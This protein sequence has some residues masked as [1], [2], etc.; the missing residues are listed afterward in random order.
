MSFDEKYFVDKY[1]NPAKKEQYK[2]FKGWAAKLHSL[3]S[4]EKALNQEFKTYSDSDLK[5]FSGKRI[6]DHFKAV[7]LTVKPKKR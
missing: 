4:V 2:Y 1:G 6:G 7:K 5:Q 3:A